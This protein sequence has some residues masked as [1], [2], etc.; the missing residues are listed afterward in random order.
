MVEAALDQWGR[1]DILINNAGFNKP[2]EH[3]D[4][5]GLSAQDFIDLYSVH[6]I[7]AYQ[8]IRAVA[9]TMKTQGKGVVVNVSSASG[10]SGYGSS[11]AYSASKG[12]INTLTKSLGRALAPA[13]RINAICPAGE[14]ARIICLGKRAIDIN[15]HEIRQIDACRPKWPLRDVLIE[16]LAVATEHVAHAGDIGDI[17]GA[18]GLIEPMIGIAAATV[19]RAEHGAHGGYI[20]DI[21]TGD[22]RAAAVVE[23]R[24]LVT[25]SADRAK[26]CLHVGDR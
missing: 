25:A 15:C 26:H 22:G 12:A 14:Q 5:D 21:P 2:V 10:E 17:P 16:A 1:V 13:I 9:P 4:L 6:V 19:A 8:M 18:N 24:P 11:V 20:G 23:V 7:G 3:D